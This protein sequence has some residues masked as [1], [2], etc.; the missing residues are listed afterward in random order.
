MK[1]V[2][3]FKSYLHEMAKIDPDKILA[4]AT[5]TDSDVK[6][7]YEK[8]NE[9]FIPVVTF[10]KE[11]FKR[12]DKK[13]QTLNH[14]GYTKLMLKGKNALC[15]N[16]DDMVEYVL[17]T[18]KDEKQDAILKRFDVLRKSFSTNYTNWMSLY[19]NP[20]S[21]LL[22]KELTK[23]DNAFDYFFKEIL[24]NPK[25]VSQAAGK[26]S[27]ATA[28]TIIGFFGDVTEILPFSFNMILQRVEEDKL[29]IQFENVKLS[30]VNYFDVI[31]S[32]TPIVG[33]D[34]IKFILKY[35]GNSSSRST[36]GVSD[37][38]SRTSTPRVYTKEEYSGDS[39][40]FV[41]GKNLY[42]KDEYRQ[43]MVVNG[44]IK[45]VK[46]TDGKVLETP[47][48]YPFSY[49]QSSAE[50]IKWLAKY[51]K[52]DAATL[53]AE[54][55]EKSANKM[56]SPT[57]PFCTNDEIS[58]Y[59]MN[60]YPECAYKFKLDSGNKK[61][62]VC[63]TCGRVL[64][65]TIGSQVP[66]NNANALMQWSTVKGAKKHNCNTYCASNNIVTETIYLIDDLY[67]YYFNGVFDFNEIDSVE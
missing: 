44:G 20:S 64:Q 37:D 9:Q 49:N 6:S 8:D 67:E 2:S 30:C 26:P 60:K 50:F 61:Y 14:I 21:D 32:K 41:V 34:R 25:L 35:E 42:V 53:A 36:S 45:K 59:F 55:K 46:D 23:K 51:R 22:Y 1:Y 29:K 27:S 56:Y 28:H 40:L 3:D 39:R 16:Q 58:D 57:T 47:A 17:K 10:L 19:N 31:N 13:L 65:N 48:K 54:Y 11:E 12:V 33:L 15:L 5:E 66:V 43:V 62:F 4:L 24:K 38:S 63:P 18:L 52:V 7:Q